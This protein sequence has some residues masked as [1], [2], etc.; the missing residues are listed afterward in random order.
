V[1]E[2][3]ESHWLPRSREEE[4]FVIKELLKYAS[5][6]DSY[7]LEPCAMSLGIPVKHIEEISALWD[8]VDTQELPRAC[9]QTI[10][11]IN[12]QLPFSNEKPVFFC[13]DRNGVC[14]QQVHEWSRGFCKVTKS[15]WCFKSRIGSKD[16]I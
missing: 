10:V 14:W 13:C 11:K 7:M 6:P 2:P 5:E 16:G 3:I 1:N 4:V 9:H 12:Q 15:K 8:G